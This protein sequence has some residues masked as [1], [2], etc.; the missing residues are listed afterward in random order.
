[1]IE[2]AG[3][4][5]QADVSAR[6]VLLTGTSGFLGSNLLKRLKQ[7]ERYT[8]LIAVDIQPPAI[9]SKKE[10]FYKV[11]LAHPRAD[12]M[13]SEIMQ[14]EQPE[15]VVHSGFYQ[16]P[17]PDTTYAHELTSIGTMHILSACAEVGIKKIVAASRTLVYGAH[18]DNPHYMTEDHTPRPRLDYE[19][20]LDKVEVERQL[21]RFWNSNPDTLVTVLRH[22][23][24]MGPNT[25]NCW[26]QY[27]S[28]PVCP[29]ILGYNP[30][31]QFISEEDVIDA[32]KLA[33]DEDYHGVFNIV[34]RRIIP[35]SM[36]LKLANK[37][38]CS[39]PYPVAA[40][41]FRGLWISRKSPFPPEHLDFLRY[42]CL[43]DGSRAKEVMGFEAKKTAWDA[44]EE[45]LEVKRLGKVGRKIETDEQPD[46]GAAEVAAEMA[47]KE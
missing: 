18:Y 7:D 24:I 4:T 32:F 1:M 19:F 29:T 46:I 45:F 3:A 31:F 20:Q 2:T 21:L 14:K 42:H 15:T 27:L 28:M 37:R 8:R 9:K 6:R 26:T 38:R 33:V 13:L 10:K 35:L 43:A 30:L 5:R 36:V 23:T 44:L 40:S 22:C 39:M 34:G 11:D 41:L 25:K 17:I 12:E 16:R 47:V